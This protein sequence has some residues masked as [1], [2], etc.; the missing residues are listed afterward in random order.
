M[1]KKSISP[2]VAT[3]LLLV[4]A[5]LSV[6]AFQTWYET[7]SSKLLA[8]SEQKNNLINNV[9]ILLVQDNI[10]YVKSNLK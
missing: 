9:D 1:F 2:V 3:A 10:L 7:F 4:V 5:V 8:D 6:V